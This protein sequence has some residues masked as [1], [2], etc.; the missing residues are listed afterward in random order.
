MNDFTPRIRSTALPPI[1]AQI[2]QGTITWP[3]QQRV[4]LLEYLADVLSE[5]VA[6]FGER[7][8]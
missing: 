4:T 6:R 1:R 2:T 5:R 7:L 8:K 3:H